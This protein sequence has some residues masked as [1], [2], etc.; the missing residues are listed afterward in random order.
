MKATSEAIVI[1]AGI[2]GSATAYFLTRG[3]LKNV[4]L[5]DKEEVHIEVD[6]IS[7]SA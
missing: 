4:L 5:L 6:N 2:A 3:G 1:G 7:A